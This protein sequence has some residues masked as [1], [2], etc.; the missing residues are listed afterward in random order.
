MR[1][2]IAERMCVRV[3]ILSEAAACSYDPVA[4]VG[5]LGRPRAPETMAARRWAA[6]IGLSYA[7]HP[8]KKD[9]GQP[10]ASINARVRAWRA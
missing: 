9:P 1:R 2:G 6:C 3:R 10:V 4:I 5:G 8:E 7:F